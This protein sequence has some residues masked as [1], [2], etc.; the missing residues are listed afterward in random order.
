MRMNYYCIPKEEAVR[1]LSIPCT[2]SM[3]LLILICCRGNEAGGS[4][5]DSTGSFF[6]DNMDSCDTALWQKTDGVMSETVDCAYRQ[7]HV[8]H[9]SGVMTITLD[10]QSNFG[11]DYTSG[12]YA[13]KLLYGYGLIEGRIWFSSTESGTVGSL[14]TFT[15]HWDGNPLSEI[16]I[17][18]LGSDPTVMWCSIVGPTS[19]WGDTVPLGFDASLGFHIYGIEWTPT[20]VS[21][22]VDG[23]VVLTGDGTILPSG[24]PARIFMNFWN[25]DYGWTGEFNYPGTPLTTEYDWIRYT[26]LTTAVPDILDLPTTSLTLH[27]PVPNPSGGMMLLRCSSTVSAAPMEFTI[28]SVS[29]RF[30]RRL[31]TSRT[32]ARECEVL[33]DGRDENGCEVPSGIYFV[34][35]IDSGREASRRIVI[36][37]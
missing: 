9:G 33:W 34:K 4:Q 6:F 20:T 29:G 26:P 35:A 3:W 28:H 21:W 1:R 18:I 19:Y 17:E 15:D 2:A 37:R 13:T 23:Q 5:A 16:D 36:L 25:G 14:F 27:P 12:E 8:T 11:Y 24:V 30:V 31:I 10:D 7:D 32:T 22:I